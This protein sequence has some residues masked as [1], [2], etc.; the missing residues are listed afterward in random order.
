[1]TIFQIECFLSIVSNKTYKKAANKLYTSQPNLSRSIKALEEELGVT[2]FNRTSHSTE[3]TPIGREFYKYA[4]LVH[5]E[6]EKFKKRLAEKNTQTISVC[7]MPESYP[8]FSDIIKEFNCLHPNIHVKI[9]EMVAENLINEIK[10]S[11][12]NT[13]VIWEHL[14][15]K[16]HYTITPIL[17]ASHYLMASKDH[18]LAS[19][20]SVS[21]SEIHNEK[22]I[23]YDEA[24]TYKFW[25]DTCR[26]AGFVPNIVTTVS[27][28]IT[29]MEL[30]KRN[31]GLSFGTNFPNLPND[32]VRLIPISELPPTSL[33]LVC[34]REA[35]NDSIHCLMNFLKERD[36]FIKEDLKN[37]FA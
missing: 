18:P 29:M 11:K 9:K 32:A 21:L 36:P 6:T 24:I 33:S 25:Y 34:H 26:S 12:T 13:V 3:L 23:F 20:A 7:A 4:L 15:P 27:S 1:M 8:F 35:Q 22:F 2:L 19:R 10:S 28:S 16:G 30:I 14:L 5:E 17:S 31:V 37:P